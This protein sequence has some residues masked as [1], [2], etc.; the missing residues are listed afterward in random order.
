MTRA[1]IRRRLPPSRADLL[2]RDDCELLA[3]VTSE[4]VGSAV[5]S[6]AC[7]ILVQR[8]EGLVRSCVLRYR[9]TPESA[10]ELMQVGYVGLIKAINNFD[11]ALGGSLAAYAQPCISGEVKR[12]FRDKRWQ[13]RVR[14][15]AQDLLL[16]V[17]TASTDLAQEL[18][19]APTDAELA[20]HLGISD[21]DL[22]EARQ[23]DRYFHA[24][25]LDAPLRHAEGLA[26]LADLLGQDDPGLDLAVEMDAVAAHW[27]ELRPRERSILLMRFYGNMTQAEIG[28]RLGLSQ[29]HVSRLQAAA[30]R[31]LRDR[32]LS[33]DPDDGVPGSA[34][35]T[36][37]TETRR[38]A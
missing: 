5:R 27:T 23:A 6:A 17:R 22:A 13:I 20:S 34:R 21:A 24:A 8:H 38:Q 28:N 1:A 19:H 14:R 29:M 31:Y 32:L 35:G 11:P 9:D 25:S 4:P 7:E 33:Q 26:K 2:R 15:S 18:G 12:H 36:S 3:L 37:L 16:R 10:E 30:L